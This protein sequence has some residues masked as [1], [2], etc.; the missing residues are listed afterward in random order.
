MSYKPLR[1]NSKINV[2][3]IIGIIGFGLFI[4]GVVGGLIY[5]FSQPTPQF[6]KTSLCPIVDGKISPK[7]NLVFLIDA[8]DPLSENQKDFVKIEMEKIIQSQEP[9]TL[10]SIYYMSDETPVQ[11]TP[12]FCLCTVPDG[13]KANKFTENEALMHKRFEKNFAKP[14]KTQLEHLDEVRKP[15]KVS[16]IFEQIQ[17][18]SVN[19]FLKYPTDGVKELYVFSDM[20][21]NSK[22]FTLYSKNQSFDVLKKSSYYAQVRSQL[23]G[24]EV[25]AFFFA[26]QPKFQ[27]N[28]NVIF[29]EKFFNDI[30]AA[31]V[32]VEPIGK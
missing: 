5:H 3:V 31:L 23:R 19:S 11:R 27:T 20:L 29:W 16:N 25:T 22:E 7:N 15:S 12:Q 21:H 24:V 10:V 18:L 30:G 1:R 32:K 17:A 4:V 28:R 9:G 6:D 13:S 2:G 14:L 26:N 8:T